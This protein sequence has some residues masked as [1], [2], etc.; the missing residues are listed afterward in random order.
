MTKPNGLSRELSNAIVAVTREMQDARVS[1]KNMPIDLAEETDLRTQAFVELGKHYLP[2]LTHQT[3]ASTWEEI[4]G[5]IGDVLL[6]RDDEARRLRVRVDQA[7]MLEESLDARWTNTNQEL[8]QA[9]YDLKSK[10]GNFQRELREDATVAQI[11]LAIDRLDRQIQKGLTNL[12]AAV[13]NADAK[14]PDYEACELFAYLKER[15]YGTAEYAG[16]LWERRWDRW[17]AQMVDFHRSARDYDLLSKTPEK[18]KQLLREKQERYKELLKRLESIREEAHLRY[19]LDAQRTLCQSLEKRL[20]EL[21]VERNEASWECVLIE[22]ELESVTELQGVY[23]QEALQI[24][25]EFLK[26]VKPETLRV[27]AAC[28]HSPV[29]DEICARI[30]KLESDIAKGKERSHRQHEQIESLLRQLAALNELSKLMHQQLGSTD[31]NIVLREDFQ[32]EVI[33][34]DLRK[35][36]ITPIAAWKRIRSAIRQEHFGGQHDHPQFDLLQGH[37]SR[38]RTLGSNAG[39]NDDLILPLERIHPLDAVFLAASQPSSTTVPAGS[40]SSAGIVLQSVRERS[41]P[42]ENITFELLAICHS[43]ADAQYV[44]TL[45]DSIGV[46]CFTRDGASDGTFMMGQWHSPPRSLDGYEVLVQSDRIDDACE[47]LSAQLEA[48]NSPWTCPKCQSTVD[49]GYHHCWR[50]GIQKRLEVIV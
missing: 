9:R 32:L 26:Q 12:E 36:A 23:Y 39:V 29:D 27:Y 43:V 46:N 8:Q 3:L 33:L 22:E 4:R 45:M 47:L 1:L 50:C 40:G 15:K 13:Q 17:V 48:H 38:S 10:Q 41:S 20:G 16:N 19:G 7:A 5:Q 11:K 28:T 18:L 34:S 30:R 2:A 25:T 6:R 44:T 35:A 49:A 31:E 37:A 42:A 21:D 14:L 24:Y